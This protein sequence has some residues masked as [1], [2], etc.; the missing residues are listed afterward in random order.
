MKYSVEFKNGA[1]IETL[2]VD[3]HTVTKTWKRENRGTITGLYSKDR[4]FCE[5]LSELL[6]E[7]TL[8]FIYETFD[9]SMLVGDIEDFIMHTNVE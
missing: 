3:S 6:D 5:Q 7:E 2:E 8:D 4:E 9:Q 1:F